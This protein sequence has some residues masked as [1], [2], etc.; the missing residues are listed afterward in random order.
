MFLLVSAKMSKCKVQGGI[1]MDLSWGV[2]DVDSIIQRRTTSPFYHLGAYLIVSA[3]RRP[4]DPICSSVQ[5][6]IFF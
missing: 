3:S 6:V 1:A 4:Q 5:F 2:V